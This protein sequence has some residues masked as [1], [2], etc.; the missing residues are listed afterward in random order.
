MS[1]AATRC[2]SRSPREAAV[3]YLEGDCLDRM[4]GLRE[5]QDKKSRKAQDDGKEVLSFKEKDSCK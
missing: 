5:G 4:S 2:R 3:G 1:P